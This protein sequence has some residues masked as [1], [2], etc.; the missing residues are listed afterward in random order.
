MKKV[1][2]SLLKTYLIDKTRET[3]A[4]FETNISE[5]NVFKNLIPF[6][7]GHNYYSRYKRV[8]PSP[9]AESKYISKYVDP[10]N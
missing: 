6:E 3:H 2:S 8:P 7:A 4:Q 9:R 10:F 1:V 5:Q